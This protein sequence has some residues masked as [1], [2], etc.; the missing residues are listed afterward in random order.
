MD[1]ST[2]HFVIIVK[3]EK[4]E[5]E[6]ILVSERERERERERESLAAGMHVGQSLA[7]YIVFCVNWHTRW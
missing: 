5:R 1:L 7:T 3:R 6:K 2:V 4:R